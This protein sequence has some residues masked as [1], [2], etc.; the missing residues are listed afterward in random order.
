MK[1][2]LSVILLLSP[3]ILRAQSLSD[4]SS[5]GL[6]GY[7]VVLWDLLKV[8]EG[9]RKK[10][11]VADFSY[12]D[13]RDSGDGYIVS[14]RLTTELV[15][16][17]K[18][19]VI[20]RKEI[21]KV[22]K[23][24]KRQYSGAVSS[25][26]VKEIGRMLGADS[27]VVGTLTELPNGQIE[28]N[29]RLVSV[30][31]G[32]ILSAASAPIRKDWLGEYR[33]LLDVQDKE[34]AQ[35]KKTA[36]S[37]SRRGMLFSD[38][39]EYDSAIASFGFAINLNPNLPDIYFNRGTAYIFTNQN[40]KAIA[41]F[42]KTIS[43]TPQSAK[44]YAGRGAAYFGKGDYDKAI[45]D[46]SR[47]VILDSEQS[48]PY[49]TRGTS[50]LSKGEYDKAIEDLSRAIA[51]EPRYAE[52]YHNRGTAYIKQ[53]KHEKAVLD[54]SKAL[55]LGLRFPSMTY[56]NR[57]NAYSTMGNYDKAINDYTKAI[58][59]DPNNAMAYCGRG[60]T[61]SKKEK[62]YD[63]ISDFNKAIELNPLFADPYYNRG[64]IYRALGDIA[65][66]EADEN[67]YKSLTQ[68]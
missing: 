55:S 28:L 56:Y 41:D 8:E 2:F 48:K 53:N 34:I 26:S 10:I 13:M 18:C 61:N 66:A 57:G 1:I 23:E 52:A 29:A 49:A 25:D 5:K 32:E 44:A 17:K 35:G 30:E 9:T 40:D 39:G 59:L 3:V 12:S 7:Q 21:E 6:T 11:A 38:L 19:V 14:E 47:A 31:S 60:A 67:K 50:Y 15:K 16:A 46:C 68:N 22:F 36:E 27:L 42:S 64:S 24:L 43:M 20:E 65:K 51:I 54:L 45:A 62:Y 4:I 58:E 63:A 37:Y 33:K